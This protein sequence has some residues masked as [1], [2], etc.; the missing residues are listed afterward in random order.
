MQLESNDFADKAAIPG[1]FAFAAISPTDHIALS[2]NRN[3][4][5]KWSAVPN[6][7]KSFALICRDNDVPSS[8]GDVNQEGREIPVSL[9]RVTFFHW[10]LMNIPAAT[11]EIPAGRH[12]DGIV[13]HGKPGPAAPDGMRHGLN[14]YTHWFAGDP[15]M[16]GEYYGYDGPC[17]PWNDALVHR[18]LF[19]LYALDVPNLDTRGD[20]TGAGLQAAL[21]GHVLAEARLTGTYTLKAL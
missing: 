18:Y 1:E 2:K 7:T 10:L 14:D 4:H 20:L 8:R 6:G 3:P 21:T 17:P 9:P 5:L 13:A 12:S 16:Q 19:T 11:R 15:N